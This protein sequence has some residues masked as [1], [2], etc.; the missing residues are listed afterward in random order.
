VFADLG[1]Q[2]EMPKRHIAIC[3]L[4]DSTTF[5]PHYLANGKIFEK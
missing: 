1:I 5:F 2:Q 4:P 3:G